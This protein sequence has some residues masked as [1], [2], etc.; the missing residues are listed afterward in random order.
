MDAPFG[1]VCGDSCFGIYYFKELEST[2]DL[3]HNTD[4]VDKDI[5][6]T[7]AQTKG[8]GQAG[9]TWTSEPGKNLTLSIVVGEH[10]LPAAKQ[11][12]LSEAI[13]LAIADTLESYRIKASV[14]WPNDIYI[15]NK[16][17]AGILIEHE[18]QG[19][20]VT[21]SVIGIGLNVNQREFDNELANATSM[22][23]EADREFDRDEVLTR[24][25]NHFSQRSDEL[26]NKDTKLIEDDYLSRLY[27]ANQPHTFTLPDGSKLQG[28]IRSVS[29]TG[30]LI[31]E[32]DEGVYRTFL[33]KEI[34][35]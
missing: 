32:V 34:I 28:T 24:L 29:E 33:F 15:G 27:L 14:K 3:A 8:R 16:K 7:D 6:I 30:E 23:I 9:N 22:A 2:N 18:I 31:V 10:G 4:Y 17:A 35:F 21:R 20:D 25:C 13:S 19:S 11:F 5:I 26:Y 12:L 1:K